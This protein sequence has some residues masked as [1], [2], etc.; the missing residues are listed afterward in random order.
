MVN[1][2]TIDVDRCVSVKYEN[3]REKQEHEFFVVPEMNRN[4]IL[5]R[6]WLKQFG[7]HMY[8]ELGC[9]RIGKSYVK[10]EED[11]HI[12]S[13]ARLT[14][15]T[16]TRPQTGKFCLCITKDNKQLFNS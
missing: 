9:I 8:Y 6:D 1:V 12:S 10:M 4:I 14:V 16:I 13:I 5:G 11:M 7:V 15:H 3:G 2:D